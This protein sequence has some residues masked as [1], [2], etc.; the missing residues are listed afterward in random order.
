MPD[1]SGHHS[2]QYLCRLCGKYLPV[3][4]IID[5]NVIFFN[6]SNSSEEQN[7]WLH[8][9]KCVEEEN[10]TRLCFTSN[11]PMSVDTIRKYGRFCSVC[12]DKAKEYY[13]GHY[14]AHPPMS[15]E[16]DEMELE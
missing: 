9:M 6:D 3:D 12:V 16:G 8:A 7:R 10:G 5:V 2:C 15:S 14:K 4:I 13:Y 11:P 1:S